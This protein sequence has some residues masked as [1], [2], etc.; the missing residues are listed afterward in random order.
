MGSN[1]INY[2]PI[3]DSLAVVVPFRHQMVGDVVGIEDD[4]LQN[5]AHL[6]QGPTDLSDLRE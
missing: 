1:N 4:T 5:L 3:G 2:R 6:K